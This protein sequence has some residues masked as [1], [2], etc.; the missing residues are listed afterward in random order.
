MIK[1][2]DESTA[3]YPYTYLPA[4]TV[5]VRSINDDGTTCS[6]TKWY[7]LDTGKELPPYY[8]YGK[9]ANKLIKKWYEDNTI[10]NGEVN[11][12]D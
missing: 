9:K 3:I 1:N 12:L 5:R 6:M 8:G 7:D 2:L 11:E 10:I 4:K